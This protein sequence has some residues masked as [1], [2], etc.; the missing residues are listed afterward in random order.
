MW[1]R[2]PVK[3]LLFDIG[4]VVVHAHLEGFLQIGSMMFGCTEEA[5]AAHTR[6]LIAEMERGEIDSYG[7][8]EELGHTLQYNG[9]GKAQAPEKL[10]LVWT[11]LLEDSLRLDESMLELCRRLRHLIPTGALSNTISEHASQLQ[12]LGVYDIFNPC[13]L[14][15]EVGMRKPDAKIY[16]MA[17]ELLNTPPQN[18]L[19]IDDLEENIAGAKAVKMQT[20]LFTG[21]ATLEGELRDL[22]LL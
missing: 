15:F 22:G 21:Q 12:Q 13:V 7:L 5:I 8:W 6:E 20:H 17:A 3:A 16:L 4:G 10:E 19:L 14:S 18:C 2:K 9:L 1:R 11:N